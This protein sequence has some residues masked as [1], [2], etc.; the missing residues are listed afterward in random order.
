MHKLFFNE[1]KKNYLKSEFKGFD[2]DKYTFN[3][4]NFQINLKILRLINKNISH[5]VINYL[6]K[7]KFFSITY[8]NPSIFNKKL[9]ITF[10]PIKNLN[11]KISAYIINYR[12]DKLS[13][14][15]KNLD[16]FFI[17]LTIF[18]LF[19][20]FLISLYLYKEI[21]NKKIFYYA[22]MHDEL[23]N[24]YNR[25]A[26]NQY[27]RNKIQEFKSFGKKFGI[28]FFDI[29]HFK[30]I[31]DSYG[32]DKG[33]F[34]LKTIANIIKNNI[35][36]DDFFGRWGG[37]EFIIIL[38]EE[39]FDNLCTIAEKLRKIVEQSDFDHLNVTSSFGVTMVR[40]DDNENSIISRVDKALYEA[41]EKGRNRVICKS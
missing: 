4:Q 5:K 35:R 18:N 1:L 40:K 30:R 28:I 27:L 26:I 9:V 25:K 16:I 33:D 19:F 41:K 23:T 36:K 2:Y 24:I 32:H 21:K 12:I 31:N 17:V 20:S 3:N 6:K 14:M 8:Y 7:G 11:N 37:E 34:V 10:V 39:N 13:F 38:N 22:S 15:L 29:D